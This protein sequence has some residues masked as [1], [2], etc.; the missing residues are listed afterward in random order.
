MTNKNPVVDVGNLV[1]V[2]IQDP[3]EPK[4]YTQQLARV[5]NVF[6]DMVIM[7]A[8]R[9]DGSRYDD[10]SFIGKYE[11]L[12]DDPD[13][14]SGKKSY[15]RIL[16]TDG[17]P[18]TIA[19]LLDTE[20]RNLNPEIVYEPVETPKRKYSLLWKFLILGYMALVTGILVGLN[21]PY[22]S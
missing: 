22:Q 10:K 18:V 9:L 5:N 14:S 19:N 1:V 17:I 12:E 20:V 21:F 3:E 7:V 15:A 13:M 6:D 16:R 4:I 2:M 8:I 11:F